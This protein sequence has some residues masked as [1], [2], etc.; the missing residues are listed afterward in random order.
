MLD[1]EQ[2]TC[3]TA[4]EQTAGRGRFHKTWVSPKGVNLYTT[5]YFCV[6]KEKTFIP[7]LGQILSIS[8]AKLLKHLGFSPQIKWP[9]DLLLQGK[10]VAGI[11]CET[12]QK[13]E[14]LGIAL[15]IGININMNSYHMSG[16]DQPVTSLLRMSHQY[17]GI[18][19]ILKDL[20][21]YFLDDLH[22]LETQGFAPFV[23]YYE[24]HLAFKEQSITV[25]DGLQTF[26]GTCKGV[27]KNGNLILLL[28]CGTKQEIL[29]GVLI[30]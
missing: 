9:N 25:K 3:I 6:P 2:I 22:T 27:T 13:E 19:K 28:P 16:I 5:F 23:P 14:S 24:G 10:K 20:I 12:I 26:Q 8:C 15:G 1:P 18:D 7:N 21:A 4:S 11:L 29:A 17:W 30:Q